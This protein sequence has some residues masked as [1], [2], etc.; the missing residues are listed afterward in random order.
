[1]AL[2]MTFENGKA[3]LQGTLDE[4]SKLEE[5][6]SQFAGDVHINMKEVRSANSVGLRTW[7]FLLS[8][9]TV[10]NK[11]QIECVTYPMA[12]QSRMVLNFFANAKVT[13][14]MAPYYCSGCEQERLVEIGTSQLGKPNTAPEAKCS[15]C[16]KVMDFDELPEFFDVL[17]KHAG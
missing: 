6:F 14:T 10:R 16:S 11:V 2:K 1:M 9:Y 8:E 4:N 12:V 7:I 5:I 17:R 13:S 15:E 3:F